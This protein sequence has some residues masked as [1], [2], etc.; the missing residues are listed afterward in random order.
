M[1]FSSKNQLSRNGQ[2][3]SCE[4]KKELSV[5]ENVESWKGRL[6]ESDLQHSSCGILWGGREAPALSSLS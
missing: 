6:K 1:G 2:G 4:H 3:C 5:M